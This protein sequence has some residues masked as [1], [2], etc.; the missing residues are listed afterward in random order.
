M[1]N[2]MIMSQF[3]FRIKI[4]LLH[5]L[6]H[7]IHV[8]SHNIC[9]VLFTN[10]YKKIA[11]LN[12]QVIHIKLDLLSLIDVYIILQTA[13]HIMY[14]K[15][16]HIHIHVH[17]KCTLQ[18]TGQLRRKFNFSYIHVHQFKCTNVNECTCRSYEIKENLSLLGLDN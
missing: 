17:T 11:L 8:H 14:M 16:Q 1:F 12:S 13:L 18:L 6:M 10:I 5:T 2:S 7:V 9:S 15:V 3:R 4:F